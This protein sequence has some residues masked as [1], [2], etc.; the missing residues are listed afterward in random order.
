[1][2]RTTIQRGVFPI[3]S[4]FTFRSGTNH[5]SAPLVYMQQG[6]FVIDIYQMPVCCR[7]NVRALGI[8][9]FGL[10]SPTAAPMQRHH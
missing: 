4:L 8:C 2:C 1:M 6:C 5:I 3:T 7:Y 10:P 9:V